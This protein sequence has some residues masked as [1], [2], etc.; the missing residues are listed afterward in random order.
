MSR[1]GNLPIKLPQ[2]VDVSFSDGEIVVK[3]ILGSLSHFTSYLVKIVLENGCLIFSSLDSTKHAKQMHGTMRALI[4][5]MVTGVS[6]GFERKLQMVGVGFN[7][8]VQGRELI[9]RAGFSH[10]VKFQI[11]EGVTVTCAV[12]TE[13]LIK[14]INNQVVGQFAA[15]VCSVRPTEPYKG[16][17]IRP[18]DKK[19]V[20]KVP[21][22]K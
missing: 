14:G 10:P 7:A 17:G 22:K 3:G 12:P 2:G 21:K 19:P 1:V 16:K 8:A 18:H 15:K 11:P 20:L 9:L 5:G 4:S 13:I 6:K